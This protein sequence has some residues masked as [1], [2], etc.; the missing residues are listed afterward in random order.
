MNIVL[1]QKKGFVIGLNFETIVM[2]IG[3]VVAI[4]ILLGVAKFTGRINIF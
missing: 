2:A 1:M 3:V 4:L